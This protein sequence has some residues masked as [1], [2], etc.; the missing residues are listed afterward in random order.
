MLY[1]LRITG[2]FGNSPITSHAAIT[3]RELRIPTVIGTRI[4]TKILNDRDWVK[5]DTGKGT[6]K[7]V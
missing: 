6:V 3:A 1:G 5:V 7:K 2:E 4:A